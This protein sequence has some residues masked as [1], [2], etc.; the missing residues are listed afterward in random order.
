MTDAKKGK[1]YDVLKDSEVI[2]NELLDLK[3]EDV[4]AQFQQSYRDA[5]RLKNMSLAEIKTTLLNFQDGIDVD[6]VI[7]S[8]LALDQINLEIA[9]LSSVYE[10]WF[11]E[12]I[13]K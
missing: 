5:L 3:V 11:G 13:T 10:D 8:E 4:K 6:D 12:S 7:E 9:K 2:E 1:I